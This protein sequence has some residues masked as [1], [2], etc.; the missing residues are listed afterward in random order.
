MSTRI[1]EEQE[2]IKKFT[3]RQASISKQNNEIREIN[4]QLRADIER[5]EETIYRESQQTDQLTVANELVQ[6][7]IQTLTKALEE[8]E[9]VNEKLRNEKTS[10]LEEY[11]NRLNN[12]ENGLQRNA[13][14]RDFIEKW[15]C[16]V[17]RNKD[18]LVFP[19]VIKNLANSLESFYASNIADQ[20]E[21]LV[22]NPTAQGDTALDSS[23]PV[24]KNTTEQESVTKGTFD[25]VD[26]HGVTSK[27]LGSPQYRNLFLIQRTR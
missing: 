5:L 15:R 18:L 26:Y 3:E 20:L 11:R 2:K 14:L 17:K 8:I 22:P 23:I 25:S 1:N 4:D 12:F 6:Q 9:R 27:L 21:S 19:S 7:R 10:L 13:I 16:Q 24:N